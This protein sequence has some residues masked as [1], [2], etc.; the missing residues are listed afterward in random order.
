MHF[1]A[2]LLSAV[3]YRVRSIERIYFETR[4]GRMVKQ[5]HVCCII[6]MF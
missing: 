6:G 5:N 2:W 1:V 3:I 4:I